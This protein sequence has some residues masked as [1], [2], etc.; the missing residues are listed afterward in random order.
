MPGHGLEERSR[1]SRRA[2][3][4]KGELTYGCTRCGML[5]RRGAIWWIQFYEHGKRLRMSSKSTDEAVARRLLKNKLARV[6]LGEPL[7]IRCAR[8]TYD[9]LRLD[10][11]NHYTTTGT[12]NLAEASSGS[13]FSKRLSRGSRRAD[14]GLDDR[15]LHGQAPGG[16]GGQRND[17][18]RG[19]GPAQD[20]APWSGA[21][22]GGPCAH[23]P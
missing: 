10:K 6:E 9:E 15:G 22:E 20:A 18:S 13:S 21:R 5:Y 1:N 3:E 23:R 14:H 11:V 16:E 19:R 8:V 4:P 2:A 7:V 17:Q 12:R